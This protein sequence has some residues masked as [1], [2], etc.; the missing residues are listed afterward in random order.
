MSR[1]A[2]A[3]ASRRRSTCRSSRLSTTS[4][5]RCRASSRT[6]C[7]TRMMSDTSTV[8]SWAHCFTLVFSPCRSS[9]RISP[10]T[11][12]A[13]ATC[14]RPPS[15]SASCARPSSTSTSRQPPIA[16]SCSLPSPSLPTR[17]RHPTA[18]SGSSRMPHALSA[19]AVALVRAAQAVQ[20]AARLQARPPSARSAWRSPRVLSP[21]R[22]MP[23]LAWRVLGSRCYRSGQS[24]SRFT[25][26]P[27]SRTSSSRRT[28]PRCTRRA[29]CATTLR[30]S[31]SSRWPSRRRWPPLAPPPR[32]RPMASLPCPSRHS[33]RSLSWSF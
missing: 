1:R 25:T 2:R 13:A 3:R 33:T 8:R 6:C 12:T 17:P 29:G 15:P 21:L 22:R 20:A 27:S 30:V 7:A 9:R 32:R 4:L 16:P 5:R 26:C 10:S 24:G 28:S 19:A 23:I 11:S 18:S 31:A 14:R